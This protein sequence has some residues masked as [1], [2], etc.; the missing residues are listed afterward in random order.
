MASTDI[1]GRFVTIPAPLC[2][3]FSLSPEM[4]HQAAGV[5]LRVV[6]FER[7]NVSEAGADL[8]QL[9]VARPPRRRRVRIAAQ[10]ERHGDMRYTRAFLAGLLR[11]DCETQ[12]AIALRH[13]IH[14]QF[15][16]ALPLMS[17]ADRRRDG[18]GVKF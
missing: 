8:A 16:S 11:A 3:L 4:S 13:R 18:D 1:P 17:F 5:R 14:I 7:A 15:R 6:F 9:L 2:Q 10:R 12:K